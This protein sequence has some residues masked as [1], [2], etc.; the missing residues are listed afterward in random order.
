MPPLTNIKFR[1]V[2]NVC[3]CVSM[4]RHAKN[5]LRQ[6]QQNQGPFST[7]KYLPCV[8][9]TVSVGSRVGSL[10]G[11][12]VGSKVGSN[13]GSKVGSTLRSQD[14]KQNRLNTGFQSTKKLYLALEKQSV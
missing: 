3:C 14:Q 9:V 5:V 12:E 6:R 10:E 13:D 2:L 4:K 7:K 1:D 11:F 8:G